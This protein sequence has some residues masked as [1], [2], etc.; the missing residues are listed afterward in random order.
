MPRPMNEGRMS[1]ESTAGAVADRSRELR[2]SASRKPNSTLNKVPRERPGE[3]LA[4]RGLGRT[5]GVAE[6]ARAPDSEQQPQ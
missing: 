2:K 1:R 3:H 6:L 5:R 4:R